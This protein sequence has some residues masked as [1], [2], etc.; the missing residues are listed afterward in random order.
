MVTELH[1]DASIFQSSNSYIF[2]Y[3]R[4]KNTNENIYIQ[5]VYIHSVYVFSPVTRR[6]REMQHCER[7]RRRKYILQCCFALLLGQ[8][9]N[10]PFCLTS[11]FLSMVI[12]CVGIDFTRNTLVTKIKGSINVEIT[13]WNLSSETSVFL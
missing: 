1:N 5:I 8:R 11:H 10:L 3:Y 12:Y 7:T 13:A 9:N 6:L 2:L 4:K